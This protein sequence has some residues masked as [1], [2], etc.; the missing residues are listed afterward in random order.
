MKKFQKL[1]FFTLSLIISL[2]NVSMF[3]VASDVETVTFTFNEGLTASD[4]EKVDFDYLETEYSEV[5]TLIRNAIE[6][7]ETTVSLSKYSITLSELEVIYTYFAYSEYEYYYFD[8]TVIHYSQSNGY[9]V[10]FYPEYTMTADEVEEIDSIIF[11]V[12]DAVAEEAS[13]FSTDI[14]KIIFIHDYVASSLEYDSDGDGSTNN[15]YSA[16]IEGTTQCVGYAQ[17]FNYIAEEAGLESE[18]VI[19][20]SKSE[21]VGHAWNLVYLDGEYYYIDCNSDDPYVNLKYAG[22]PLSGAWRYLYLMCSDDSFSTITADYDTWTVNGIDVSSDFATSTTYDD[23]FWHTMENKL[24]YCD[25]YWYYTQCFHTTYTRGFYIYRVTFTSNSTYTRK[26][27]KTVYTAWS[28]SSGSYS[29]NF[30]STLQIIGDEIY[31]MSNEGIYLLNTDSTDAEDDTLVFENTTGYNLFDFVINDDGTSSVLYGEDNELYDDDADVRTY[32]ISDYFCATLGHIGDSTSGTA[33]CTRCGNK[34]SPSGGTSHEYTAVITTAATCTTDGVIT[35]TCSICGD[36]YTETIAATGHT[37]KSTT[38]AAT[39]TTNKIVTYTC[40]TC[41]YSYTTETANTALGHLY[42][43]TVT[44]ATCTDD[45]YTTYVCSRCGDTYIL[46]NSGTATGHKYSSVVTAPTCT[47][48]GYTTYTCSVCGYSY[49]SDYTSS[50]GTAHSYTSVTTAA[51]CT[52]NAYVTYTCSTCGY[53]YVEEE[54]DTATG[55]TYVLKTTVAATCTTDGYETYACSDCGL[56]YSVTI[57]ATGHTYVKSSTTVATCTEGGTTTYKCSV[58]GSSYTETTSSATGHTYSWVIVNLKPTKKCSVCGYK[59]ITLKF[60]DIS[61]SE[62]KG[63]YNYIAY[64]SYYNSFIKGTATYSFSPGKSLTRAAFVTIL[65]RMSGSPYDS[66]NPYGTSKNPFKDVKTSAYYYNAACWALDYGVTTETTFKGT[67]S[68]TREQTVTFLYRYAKK[69]TDADMST[70]SISSFPDASKVSSWAKTA[71]K[72][73]YK[74]GLITG[75]SAGKINPQGTTYRIYASKIF[76][77][78]GVACDI[79]TFES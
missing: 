13:Q 58:C 63:Y 30:Y 1:I 45:S 5:V 75:N 16:V 12:L 19:F 11:P 8:N 18:V 14:E 71:M 40:S 38:T 33:T 59:K 76:Y 55:H 61:S 10:A 26:R 22:S 57:S 66:S 70:K 49:V 68:V 48:N 9:V 44:A 78:F 47:D 60:N 31:Y 2:S 3:A 25:G 56:S 36:T 15:L 4:S 51:T 20:Q 52:E 62:Y 39:C 69:F 54:E 17:M 41:G 29:T 74:N 67:V 7:F 53:S 27:M 32:N 79:G 24:Y 34:F 46:T 37:Y 72:W 42:S 43:G 23:M 6:N 64:T 50:L 65:Y 21:I 73:A 77:K 35:Y 28:T